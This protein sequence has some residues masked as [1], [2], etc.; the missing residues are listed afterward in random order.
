MISEAPTWQVLCQLN[1]LPDGSSRG[2]SLPADSPGQGLEI[3]LVR[4]GNVVYGYRNRC[5]HTGAPLD[6]NP[7]QFL[8]ERGELIQC[9]LHGALFAIESGVCLRG[10]CAGKSLK[11]LPLRVTE[12][13]QVILGRP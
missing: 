6:W 10:P 12:D 1:E 11:A 13:G 4:R 7:H 9:A 8:D 5:P 2:F 3:F